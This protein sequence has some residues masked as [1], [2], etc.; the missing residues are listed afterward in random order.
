MGLDVWSTVARPVVAGPDVQSQ[1]TSMG[2]RLRG[3]L[4]IASCLAALVTGGL[5]PVTAVGAQA[6]PGLAEIAQTGRTAMAAGDF[7]AAVSAY[8]RLAEALPDDPG[9]ALNLGMALHMTGAFAPALERLRFALDSGVGG[10]RALYLIGTAYLALDRLEPAIE[11]LKG[12]LNANPAMIEATGALAQALSRQGSH[13]EAARH[14][15]RWT[16]LAPDAP[17]A[18]FGLAA[19]YSTLAQAALD[20]LEREA[21]ESAYMVALA[22]E[23]QVAR[24]QDASAF[25]LFREALRRDPGLAGVHRGIAAIYRRAGQDAWA[26]REEK[27]EVGYAD[28]DCQ[29][30]EL[31]CLY[32]RERWAELAE[33]ARARSGP[34]AH[35]WTSRAFDAMSRDARDRLQ[36][37]P[38]SVEGYELSARTSGEQQRHAEAAASW[39]AALAL[40]PGDPRLEMEL[41]ISLQQGRKFDEAL[42]MLQRLVK[43]APDSIELNYSLG[44]ALANLQRPA[45]AIPHL[46]LVATRAPDF[47]PA[48]ATLGLAL[49]RL[50]Q[51]AQA[52]AHLEAALPADSDASTHF[53]LAQAYRQLGR[54]QEARE[55]LERYQHVKRLVD[56]RAE[57]AKG[58]RITPP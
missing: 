24:G 8:S 31:A 55:M 34:A 49:M 5:A 33:A 45:E 21:P 56:E 9:V 3:R 50:D 32:G 47:L 46:K 12:A 2:L 54:D 42:P 14:F 39:R 10:E 22:A 23:V 17:A 37:L 51:A 57:Y 16:D 30:R 26:E 11:S 58:L 52:V 7:A 4:A 13:R 35:F 6:S 28:S 48:R 38:P 18:W 19:S 15:R 44:H 43:R 25:Q 29:S 27:R 20:A 41:A 1:L 53:R 36:A 40:R